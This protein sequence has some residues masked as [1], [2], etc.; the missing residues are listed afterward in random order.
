MLNY[1]SDDKYAEPFF[2]IFLDT[3]NSATEAQTSCTMQYWLGM[4]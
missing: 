2:T 1:M 4:R 3:E